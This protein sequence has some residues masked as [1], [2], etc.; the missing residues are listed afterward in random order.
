M[1]DNIIPHFTETSSQHDPPE[2]GWLHVAGVHCPACLAAGGFVGAGLFV[3]LPGPFSGPCP[4][5]PRPFGP[6][7]WCLCWEH[8]PPGHWS[9]G[10]FGSAGFCWAIADSGMPSTVKDIMRG[11]IRWSCVFIKVVTPAVPE[12][13][14]AFDLF[15]W[16]AA[17]QGADHQET[18]P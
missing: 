11:T 7:L 12:S 1:I 6:P 14:F 3:P 15:P 9:P 17:Q 16:V 13:F 4:L 10:G 5:G 8:P 18:R 2:S